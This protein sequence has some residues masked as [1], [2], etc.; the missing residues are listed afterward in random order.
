MS[1]YYDADYRNDKWIQTGWTNNAGLS[2][3]MVFYQY[4]DANN[5]IWDDFVD[6][7]YGTG[8]VTF[9]L[10]RNWQYSTNRWCFSASGHEFACTNPEHN[11][12]W[13]KEQVEYY[14]ET[15][16]TTNRLYG[17]TSDPV[18]FSNLGYR[19]GNRVWHATTAK[20]RSHSKLGPDP[21]FSHYHGCSPAGTVVEGFNVY[22]DRR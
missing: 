13:P 14:A 18:T 20:C 6:N 17:S 22:D 19:D 2:N 1:S 10:Y 12:S 3:T 9:A 16:R 15:N 5:Q 21:L 7:R 8:M 11:M 4:V